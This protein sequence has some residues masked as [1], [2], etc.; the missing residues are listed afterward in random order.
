MNTSIL[1]N[2]NQNLANI[3]SVFEEASLGSTYQFDAVQTEDGSV[4]L[5]LTDE[6]TGAEQIILI[7]GENGNTVNVDESGNIVISSEDFLSVA[8]EYTNTSI[9]NLINSAPENL[10][11]LGK[12]ATA[13]EEHKEAT[14]ALSETVANKQNKNVIVYKDSTTG[15]ASMTATEILEKVKAGDNLYYTANLYEGTLHPY[16][17]G[18]TQI[19]FFYSNYVDNTRVMGTGISIDAEGNIT[20]ETYQLAHLK[21][22]TIHIT[23]AEREKWNSIPNNLL[24][25]SAAGSL[26]GINTL[27]ESDS[28][29]IGENAFAIGK[30]T[31]ASGK[32]SFASGQASEATGSYAHAE[33]LATTAKS[34]YSHS[35]GKHTI[36]SSPAQHVEGAANIEDTNSTYIHI[37]GNGDFGAPSNAHTLDWNGNAWYSGDVYV[38][39]TSGKNKDEG[40]KKLATEEYVLALLASYSAGSGFCESE[41]D[42]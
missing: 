27:A 29:T 31:K 5:K 2:I 33:G 40:S 24:N 8:K 20:T 36:A 34:N 11:T 3:L 16:L 32:N 35:E 12:L 4:S 37:A 1:S 10:N 6:N 13:F 30:E 14:D 28:Y 25:G 23:A 9:T 22:T 38:G 17:E 39:S 7:T 18:S 15:K 19:A 42:M 21:D 41:E 26:R